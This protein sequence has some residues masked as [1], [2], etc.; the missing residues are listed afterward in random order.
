MSA[1][2]SFVL[3]QF[4]HVTDRRTDGIAITNTS[5]AYNGQL[6]HGSTMVVMSILG[7][8]FMHNAIKFDM[9]LGE[10]IIMLCAQGRGRH[11]C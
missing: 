7:N 11:W 1:E 10:K 5:L 4:T 6:V 9:V 8:M 2:L 3:S